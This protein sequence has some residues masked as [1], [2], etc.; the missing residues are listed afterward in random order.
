MAMARKMRMGRYSLSRSSTG[1][2]FG[3]RGAGPRR[4]IGCAPFTPAPRRGQPKAGRKAPLRQGFQVLYT[5]VS[6]AHIAAVRHAANAGATWAVAGVG[7]RK[8]DRDGERSFGTRPEA[9]TGRPGPS[10]R[11]RRHPFAAQIGLRRS[12]KAAMPSSASALSQRVTRA[13][14]VSAITPSSIS[15]PRRRTSALASATAPGAQDEIGRD[16]G[17]DRGVERLGRHGPRQKAQPHRLVGVETAGR[18]E[19]PP[20]HRLAHPRD[21]I[22]PDGRRDQAQPR[23]GQAEHRARTRRSPRRRPRSS[24]C[25]RRRPGPAPARSAAWAGR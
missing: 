12:K 14:M 4:R 20:R 21:D 25:R 1:G 2:S 11:S 3:S 16:F 17:L 8:I 22:G 23:L 15:G 6:I 24:R 10:G 9:A 7:L 18:H 5:I 13:A 19:D